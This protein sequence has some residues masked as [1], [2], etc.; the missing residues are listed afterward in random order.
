[1]GNRDTACETTV[2]CIEYHGE[3]KSFNREEYTN[4]HVE[5]YNSNTTLN[6][7]GFNDWSYAQKFHYLNK[8]IKTNFIDTCL[9][10]ISRSAVLRGD[11]TTAA[12][13]VDDFLVIM[14][15]CDPGINRNISGVDTNQGD[16]GG[17]GRGGG[18]GRGVWGGGGGRSHERGGHG[19]PPHDAIG[20]YTHITKSY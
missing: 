8:I 19:F 6:A 3:K 16:G 4:P 10:N 13:H 11:F 12:R 18:S 5:Q 2:G 14:K 7:H 20:T 17:R 9:A 1:M 15:Y